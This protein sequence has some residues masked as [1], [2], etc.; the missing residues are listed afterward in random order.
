MTQVVRCK[1]NVLT[2]L[3][4]LLTYLP[5]VP[6]SRVLGAC[7]IAESTD[8]WVSWMRCADW[9]FTSCLKKPHGSRSCHEWMLQPRSL[10]FSTFFE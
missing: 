5:S 1:S 9:S 4:H 8:K 10:G 7:L 6:T 2:A 3:E